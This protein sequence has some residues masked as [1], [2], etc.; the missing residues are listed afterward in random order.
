MQKAIGLIK[1]ALFLG[2]QY[3]GEDQNVDVE[4]VD[5]E[6]EGMDDA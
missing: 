2:L 1:Y 6:R 4:V 3:E 5:D